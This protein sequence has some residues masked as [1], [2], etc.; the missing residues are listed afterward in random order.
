MNMISD[1][2]SVCPDLIY[3]KF[4]AYLFCFATGI[5]SEVC[6]LEASH[7]WDINQ[8]VCGTERILVYNYEQIPGTMT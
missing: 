8:C 3:G 5:R 2:F 7:V 1:Q 6:Y 4:M